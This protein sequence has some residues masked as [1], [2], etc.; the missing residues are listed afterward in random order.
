MVKFPT[1]L[2]GVR[3]GFI[4][5]YMVTC[6]HHGCAKMPIPGEGTQGFGTARGTCTSEVAVHLQVAK[7]KPC[8]KMIHSDVE[9]V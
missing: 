3:K 7:E 2:Q 5:R 8:P 6:V 9:N 4:L 1:K